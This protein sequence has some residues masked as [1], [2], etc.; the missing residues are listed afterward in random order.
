MVAESTFTTANGNDFWSL[1]ALVESPAAGQTLNSLCMSAEV[2]ATDTFDDD[3]LPDGEW[4]VNG[5]AWVYTAAG[6]V[7]GSSAT[8]ILPPRERATCTV[9]ASACSSSPVF[10]AMRRTANAAHG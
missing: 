7:T 6:D 3:A 5:P 9:T 10:T 8:P 4:F 1:Q 2:P